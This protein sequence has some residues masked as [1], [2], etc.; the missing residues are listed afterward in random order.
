LTKL[1]ALDAL[2]VAC[3]NFFVRHCVAREYV[4][5]G[6]AL[7]VPEL[8]DGQYF[9]IV[10]STFNDGLHVYPASDLKDEAFTGMVWTMAVPS[11]FERLAEQVAEWTEK[12]GEADGPYS[13]ES[14]GGYSYARRS[15]EDGSTGWRAAFASEIR[16]WK[17]L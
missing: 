7:E 10:G 15:S 9:R 4:V 5:S 1:E 17:K 2:T 16:R 11:T 14:F 12:H 13:S 3:N 6:G 8:A